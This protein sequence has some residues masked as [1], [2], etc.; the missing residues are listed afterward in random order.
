VHRIHEATKVLLSEDA[1]SSKGYGACE[2]QTGMPGWINTTSIE[3]IATSSVVSSHNIV[4]MGNSLQA[5]TCS[6]HGVVKFTS[7]KGVAT[8]QLDPNLREPSTKN[9]LCSPLA[10]MVFL[11]GV[12]ENGTAPITRSVA[13]QLE[14]HGGLRIF[15]EEPQDVLI[16]FDGITYHPDAQGNTSPNVCV[17]YCFPES[18]GGEHMTT[19]GCVKACTPPMLVQDASGSQFIADC[20]CNM[21]KRLECWKQN[22]RPLQCGQYKK[23][24]RMHSLASK[25]NADP[26]KCGEICARQLAAL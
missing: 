3:G 12:V 22:G 2:R 1:H 19:S 4:V 5:R 8:A 23:L 18:A 9:P 16:R 15:G 13:L 10:A 20:Q 6:L 7:I 21:I 11:A 26:N 24:L 14:P 25:Q 17:P